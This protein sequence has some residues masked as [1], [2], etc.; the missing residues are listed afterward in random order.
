MN[1]MKSVACTYATRTEKCPFVAEA[2]TDEQI[3]IEMHRHA[4]TDHADI[5]THMSPTD[6]DIA[7]KKIMKFAAKAA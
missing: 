5:V 3:F 6:H 7:K 1:K 4:L 2:E